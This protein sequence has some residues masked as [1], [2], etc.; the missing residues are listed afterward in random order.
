[1]VL[2]SLVALVIAVA[3]STV[4]AFGWSI[5]VGLL[6][7]LYFAQQRITR[8]FRGAW[9]RTAEANAELC[10]EL[11]DFVAF[12]ATMQ[13]RFASRWETDARGRG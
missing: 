2:G 4:P 7:L 5:E 13:E 8:L 6:T 10:G 12:N 9:R 3:F 1:M 11:S